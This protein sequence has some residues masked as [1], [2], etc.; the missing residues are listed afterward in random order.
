MTATTRTTRRAAR[1]ATLRAMLAHHAEQINRQAARQG[2]TATA[3]DTIPGIPRATVEG[4]RSELR[5]IEANPHG[6]I[7]SEREW[8]TVE[9]AVFGLRRAA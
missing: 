9:D 3:F 8:I 2:R 7:Q 1:A 5:A 4:R 6:L